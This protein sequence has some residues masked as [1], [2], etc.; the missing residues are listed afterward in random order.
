MTDVVLPPSETPISLDQAREL[1]PGG[2]KSKQTLWRWAM[3][4]IRGVRLEHLLVGKEI[5]TSEDALRRFFARV[6]AAGERERRRTQD[7]PRAERVERALK[8][9]DGKI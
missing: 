6:T 7:G 3:Q 2:P 8:E 9:L 4:G 1:V 5:F